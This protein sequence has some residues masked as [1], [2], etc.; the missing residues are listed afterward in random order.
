MSIVALL[1]VC[2]ASAQLLGGQFALSGKEITTKA[3]EQNVYVARLAYKIT[4][5]QSGKS[6]GR[7]GKDE[8]SSML[9]VA[10]RT[11]DGTLL[12]S[13]SLAPWKTD[14]DF[15]KYADDY[16]GVLTGVMLCGVTDSLYAPASL[17]ASVSNSYEFVDAQTTGGLVIDGQQGVKKGWVVWV[18]AESNGTKAPANVLMDAQKVELNLNDTTSRH[19]IAIVPKI[20]NIIGGIYVEPCYKPAGIV[21]YRLVGLVERFLGKWCV[22]TPFKGGA[23]VPPATVE[24]IEGSDVLTEIGAGNDSGDQ[25][26]A[27]KAQ[28]QTNK[29][30]SKKKK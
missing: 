2:G 17:P 20:N 9:S 14:D 15:K 12:S 24:K 19:E 13:A 10:V 30:K 4:D 29:K 16:D 22:Y 8:F 7:N 11:E 18:A 26:K 5:K 1:C 21:Q 6:F 23:Q 27:D 3:V 28:E 25:E